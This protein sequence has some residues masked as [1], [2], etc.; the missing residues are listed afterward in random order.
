MTTRALTFYGTTIGKKVAMA[1]SGLIV[2][3]W[4]FAHMLG[5]ITI[6]AGPEAVNKYAAILRENPPILWGQRIVMLAAIGV[7]IHAAFALWAVNNDARPR[8]YHQRKNQATDYAAL[9]M[10]Y[11]GITILLFIFYHIAHLTL[12]QTAHLGYEFDAQNVYANVVLGFSNPIVAGFYLLAQAALSLHLYHGIW[13]LTQTLG[14]EHPRF[15]KLRKGA[16]VALTA[17]IVLGFVS[18][19]VAVQLGTLAPPDAVEMQAEEV[20]ET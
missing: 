18:I 6:F 7:H 19:P 20:E 17:I 5:N 8:S 10:R 14:V 3:G 12:G 16:A 11:G 1:V 9:T 4:L 15:D 2:V 13:S